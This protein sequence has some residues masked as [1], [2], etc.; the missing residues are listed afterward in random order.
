MNGLRQH[1]LISL[2]LHFR[3]RMALLY[4]YLFPLIFLLAFWVLY[5]HERVPL[6]NHFGALLTI[7]ILGGSCFGLPTTLVSE[8]EA[9]TWRRYRT[10]P[11][12][13]WAFVLSTG[14]SRY[15][16]L[17][18]AGLV[19][20][21]VALALGMPGPAHPVELAV[22]FTL[23][24]F[25]FIGIGLVI[26]MLADSVPAVQAL[27]QCVFLPMLMIGGVAVPL[28]T[29]PEWTQRVSAFLP[30]RYAVD[31]LQAAMMAGRAPPGDVRFNLLALI[32]IGVAGGLAGASLFRWEI[33]QPLW[34]RANKVGLVIA[35]A[36]WLAQGAIVEERGRISGLQESVSAVA[37]APAD[38]TRPW[39]VVTASDVAAL[40]F[41][42]PPDYGLVTPIAESDEIR[43]PE[44]RAVVERV[45]VKLAKWAPGHGPDDVQNVRNLLA[46]A[47]VADI[48]ESRTE[49]YLPRMLLPYLAGRYPKDKLVRILTWIAQH[50]QEGT[51]IDDLAE[52]G[53][54]A[55]VSQPAMIQRRNYF[56]ALKFIARLTN[57]TDHRP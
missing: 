9:G 7:S 25:A 19:Q 45:R 17:A 40:N 12:P 8:R 54:E 21:G 50:P 6:F 38:P 39:E 24:S 3:N 57:R 28:V 30:G 53:L 4:G 29:L 31:A 10:T 23:A 52:F 34:A 16:L 51:V 20:L 22:A 33:A 32:L 41:N 18:S 14:T 43:D 13:T 35:L 27:G 49:R 5:R 1:F 2:R 47:S 37:P 44:L 11:L 26:A 42:V 55:S 15:V 46:I 48:A 36:A 56:Y